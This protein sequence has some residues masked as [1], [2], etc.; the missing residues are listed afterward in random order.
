[1]SKIQHACDYIHVTQSFK[2]AWGVE[3]DAWN[4]GAEKKKGLETENE[5]K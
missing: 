4:E 5:V 2:Q 1:M 3:G